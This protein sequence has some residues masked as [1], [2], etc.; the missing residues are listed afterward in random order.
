MQID[1]KAAQKAL[2]SKEIKSLK[3]MKMD[4]MFHKDGQLDKTGETSGQKYEDKGTW[5]FV[6]AEELE[7]V[8]RKITIN[9]KGPKG[10]SKPIDFILDG[11]DAFEIPLIV[12]E[13]KV[14]A[15]RF[16]E[17]QDWQQFEMYREVRQSGPLTVTLALHGLGDV[18]IDRLRI[19]AIDR[20]AS[21]ASHSDDTGKAGVKSPRDRFP[22][23]PRFA[24]LMGPK[25]PA[26]E[27]EKP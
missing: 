5:E 9:E 6:G 15:M 16:H 17:S 12:K 7:T 10:E 22:G 25:K 26:V 11:D 14:G 13:V 8:I 2:E 3:S 19:A 24:P 20:V 18:Q 27:T 23:L 21:T 4:L 1:E